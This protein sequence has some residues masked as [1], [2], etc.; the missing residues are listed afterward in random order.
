MEPGLKLRLE[1][2]DRVLVTLPGSPW[3]QDPSE[4][5]VPPASLS[6]PRESQGQ[7]P[8]SPPS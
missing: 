8:F 4:P 5:S 6:L 1:A 2:P 3:T 7:V